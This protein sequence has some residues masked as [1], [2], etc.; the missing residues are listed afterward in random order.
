MRPFPTALGALA[1]A[2]LLVC[3]PA[4]PAAAKK[5][6]KGPSG[7]AFYSPPKKLPKGAHGTLIRARRVSSKSPVAVPGA[8]RTTLVLYRSRAVRGGATAVSGLVS[9]PRGKPPKRG[10]PVISYAHGTSGI[11]DR[12]APSRD[13]GKGAVHAYHAYVFP[14]LTRWLKAG[15]A[16]VRTDYEGLGTPG[17]HPYLIGRSEGRAVL[18]MARAARKLDKRIGRRMIVAGHSQGGH[19]ALWAG[20]MARSYTPELS[21]RGTVAYAPAANL[22]DQV[23]LA[24]ALTTPGGGLSGLVATIVRGL[25]VARTPRN[26]T[27]VLSD[28][29]LGLYP[30]TLTECTPDLAA[31]GSFGGV[32]PAALLRTGA[33]QTGVIAALRSN[34]PERLRFGRKPVRIDQGAADGTVL[35]PFTLSLVQKLKAN[36]AKSLTYRSYKGVDHG[37]IVQ[38]AARTSTTWIARRLR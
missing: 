31:D 1:V 30:R 29:A 24:T 11:A 3:A 34:G 19:A 13:T 2:A 17:E 4:A 26:A 8:A 14:L 28:V 15:Y 27:S 33:D 20:S 23:P 12:C 6:P 16:V 38:K 25:D 10:W 36:G 9:V 7:S 18:D 5:I 37:G 32:A 21:L 22:A 35:P